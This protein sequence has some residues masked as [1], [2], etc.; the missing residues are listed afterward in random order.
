M[1]QLAK[2][3]I[4]DAK[5]NPIFNVT[6]AANNASI[7]HANGNESNEI[8]RTSS[9]D[10]FSDYMGSDLFR[11]PNWNIKDFI[12]ER[13]K[14][15]TQGMPGSTASPYNDP[16]LFFYKLFFNFNTGFG[17]FG[18]LIKTTNNKYISDDNSAWQY[19]TNNIMGNKFS[20][21]YRAVLLNKR[22]SLETFAK[23][24]NYLTL[25]CPWFFKEITGLE[26]ALQYKFNNIVVNDSNRLTLVFNEDAVDM[27]ISTL[28][29][30]YKDAC[31]DYKNF[32]EVIPENLR[33]FDMSVLIF[34]PP[35]YG[36]NL[37]KDY[38]TPK[39]SSTNGDNLTFKCIIFKNCEFEYE[40]L[41]CLPTAINNEIG[42]AHV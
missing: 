9:N 34:N 28:I 22:K 5:L 37:Y 36:V 6:N 7:I 30:L 15:K 41:T 24:L 29:N 4:N 20:K 18:S 21:N 25:E 14:F 2:R 42:R 3:K 26:E 32:K 11:I 31:F 13:I 27:R 39:F 40:K 16:G 35:I 23:L 19:L 17:L 1:A 12:Y 8:I 33:K 10:G 38:K